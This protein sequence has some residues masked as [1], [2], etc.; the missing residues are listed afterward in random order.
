MRGR[1]HKMQ[2]LLS[3]IESRAGGKR[4]VGGL[5]ID[6]MLK[7][8]VRDSRIY[9]Q[10]GGERGKLEY[11]GGGVL[12]SGTVSGIMAY[13]ARGGMRYTVYKTDS[14]VNAMGKTLTF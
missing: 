8:Q 7:R 14:Q 10:G 9:G 3:G 12:T 5:Q 1:I 11:V 13:K 6:R 4:E 2:C